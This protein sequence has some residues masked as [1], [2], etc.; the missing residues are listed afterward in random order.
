M[1]AVD[2]HRCPQV[3]ETRRA[4]DEVLRAQ[5]ADDPFALR[6]GRQYQVVV[7][8]EDIRLVAEVLQHVELRH[9]LL[10]VGDYLALEAL[11]NCRS[12]LE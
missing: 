7:G 9:S 1:V 3:E 2:H 4:A 11:G 12:R 8:L 10:Q 5:D 6:I